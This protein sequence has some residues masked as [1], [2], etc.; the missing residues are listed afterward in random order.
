MAFATGAAL[1]LLR[2]DERSGTPLRE[3]LINDGVTHASLPAGGLAD[4]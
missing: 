4:H 2:D 1:V 3:V